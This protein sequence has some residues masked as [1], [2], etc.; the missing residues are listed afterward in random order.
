MKSCVAASR[1]AHGFRGITWTRRPRSGEPV[2]R[3]RALPP[4]RSHGHDW[5]NP[6]GS[7]LT[8][9]REKVWAAERP[10]V[11]QGIDVGGKMGV[12]KMRDGSLWVHSPVDLDDHLRA[13]LTEIGT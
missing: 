12:V 9:L 2:R 13:A 6:S 3:A 8:P 1:P 4:P 10:F 5:S 11:W 7:V